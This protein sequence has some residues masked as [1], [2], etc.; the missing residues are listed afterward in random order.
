MRRAMRSYVVCL[1]AIIFSIVFN[2]KTVGQIFPDSISE[3]IDGLEP[4][5]K[6]DTLLA[7]T[8]SNR[9]KNP[10]LA[11]AFAKKGIAIAR[12][13][14]INKPL[15]QLY[16]FTGVIYQHYKDQTEKAIPFYHESLKV[17]I[18]END[19]S[20]LGYVYNNLGDAF[21]KIGN[22]PLAEEYANK[23][24]EVFQSLNHTK[25]IAYSYINI[26]FVNRIQENYEKALSSFRKAIEIRETINDSVGIAS[27]TLELGRTYKAKGEYDEAMKYFR[28]SLELHREINNK[29]YMAY[30]LNG[31]GDIF[32]I[33]KNYDAALER[34]KKAI[35]LNEERGNATGI[36]NDYLGVALVYSEI[37]EKHLGEKYITMAFD[38]AKAS[39]NSR[40]LLKAFETKARFYENIGEYRTANK[41][42]RKY[43]E[44]Y[45]SLYS[46][47]QF[48]TLSE[49]K[50]RFAITEKLSETSKSLEAK[51][52]EQIYFYSLIL[53]LLIIAI[54]LITRYRA[55]VK[56]NNKLQKINHTKDKVFSVI[57][58]D[59]KSPFNSLIGFS[60][61][62]MEELEERNYEDAKHQAYLLNKT[63][64]DSFMLINNLLN[65]SRSQRESISFEPEELLLDEVVNSVLS[66]AESAA[67]E[68]NISIHKQYDENLTLMADQDLLNTI[69][70]NLITNA[71]KFTHVEGKVSIEAKKDGQNI[72]ISIIDNGVGISDENLKKL[73]DLGESFSTRGTGNEKGTG[74]GLMVCKDF[75]ELHG[76]TIN[77]ESTQGKG[78]RFTFS[79]PQE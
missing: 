28:K 30:S 26:G 54:G 61:V 69:L 39:S 9:E 57:S 75:V 47:Q 29:Q 51:R 27:A 71:I 37:N 41:S 50:D 20:Q 67:E 33:K 42:Y 22:V 52:K 70:T 5:E 35:K 72:R 40:S 21:Y 79:I 49:I 65:W 78:S 11:L 74:L 13:H 24:M 16:G 12:E 59:L 60:E 63:A 23:S 2:E 36:I 66:I 38:K 6:I 43:L 34:Y 25:G 7:L 10:D 45:D 1:F 76:G 53:L 64:N 17:S 31:M 62:L 56:M 44:I 19:S 73:F 8:W 4:S 32:L 77:I 68:K 15:T 48:Q 58:H 18:Q 3:R 55:K 14:K 46:Q